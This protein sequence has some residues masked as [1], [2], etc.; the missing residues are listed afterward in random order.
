M[1]DLNNIYEIGNENQTK[2]IYRKWVIELVEYTGVNSRRVHLYTGSGVFF[3]SRSEAR[4][5]AKALRGNY[6]WTTRVRKYS[7]TK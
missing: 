6:G 1:N 3:D 4:R 7:A 2:N 5:C